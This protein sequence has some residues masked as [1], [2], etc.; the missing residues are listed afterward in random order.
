MKKLLVFLL[1][2]LI[3][4]FPL[5]AFAEEMENVEDSTVVETPV[6]EET[7]PNDNTPDGDSAGTP[8]GD[9]PADAPT[10]ETPVEDIKTTVL[11]VSDAIVDWIMENKEAIAF[12]VSII[13]SCVAIYVKLG[14]NTKATRVMN[15]NA[16]T[17]ATESAAQM[18]EA[19][20]VISNAATVVTGY[21]A[22]ITELL[23]AFT[24]L[25]EEN[26]TLKA[27]VTELK[28]YLHTAT[29]ANVELGNEI[30]ELLELA[31]IPNHVKDRMGTRHLEA[32][33]AILDAEARANVVMADTKAVDATVEEVKEND[34][35]EA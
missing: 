18:S 5:T 34:S 3:L 6:E 26:K 13:G 21:D 14:A 31:N 24:K 28:N 15:D 22:K 12:I 8:E 23:G 25:M 2:F 20:G 32:V 29:D 11:T 1:C 4:C 35:K 30:G 17:I 19:Q 9:I 10:E 7:P 33:R 27:D 16:V